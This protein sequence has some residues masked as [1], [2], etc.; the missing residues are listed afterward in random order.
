MSNYVPYLRDLLDRIDAL[1]TFVE[2]D[3]GVMAD[4]VPASMQQPIKEITRCQL[5]YSFLRHMS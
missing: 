1:R 2:T 4:K 3:C 5:V